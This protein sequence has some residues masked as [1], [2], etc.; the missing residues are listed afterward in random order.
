MIIKVCT[1]RRGSLLA[2]GGGILLAISISLFGTVK[3]VRLSEA[4]LFQSRGSNELLTVKDFSCKGL[5]GYA[6]CGSVNQR[7]MVC[8]TAT[9]KDTMMGSGGGY[10]RGLG[11]GACGDTYSGVCNANLVCVSLM[12]PGIPCILPPSEPTA[13]SSSPSRVRSHTEE[14]N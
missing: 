14:S 3:Q 9:Y 7:C 12:G 6:D 10:N 13:Q 8:S 5:S 2:I 11:N 1:V 4:I